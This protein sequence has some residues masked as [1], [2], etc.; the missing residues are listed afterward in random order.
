M[1]SPL[2]YDCAAAA[3]FVVED[4]G[5]TIL[6]VACIL[7]ARDALRG[8]PSDEEGDGERTREIAIFDEECERVARR[9]RLPEQVVAAVLAADQ[10]YAESVGLIEWTVT[11]VPPLG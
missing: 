2:V 4:T 1:T 10:R 3:A 8:W 11:L 7:R 5:A 6:T 9:T